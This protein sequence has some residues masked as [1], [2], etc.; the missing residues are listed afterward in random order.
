MAAGGCTPGSSVLT[1]DWPWVAH[2]GHHSGPHTHTS[3]GYSVEPAFQ[4]V[5]IFLSRAWPPVED[6]LVVVEQL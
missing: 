5:A 1:R 2:L 4:A 6:S 3:Q